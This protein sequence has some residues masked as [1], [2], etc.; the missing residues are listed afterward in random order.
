MPD[1][2]QSGNEGQ[3]GSSQQ[4]GGSQEGVISGVKCFQEDSH[5]G[6]RM[7]ADESADGSPR[8]G[9]LRRRAAGAVGTAVPEQQRSWRP[10]GT[11]VSRAW[12][13]GQ[14]SRE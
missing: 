11:E 3:R 14:Q 12:E 8:D 1:T 2:E 5:P 4:A 7:L 9:P 13:E 6:R 10:D